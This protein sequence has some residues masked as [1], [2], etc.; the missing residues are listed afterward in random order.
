MRQVLIEGETH[1]LAALTKSDKLPPGQ[2]RTR[3]RELRE[4]LELPED[5]VVVTSAKTGEGIT[6]LRDAIGLLIGGERS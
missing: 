3:G 2:R 4:D 1:V 5:Q 6:E